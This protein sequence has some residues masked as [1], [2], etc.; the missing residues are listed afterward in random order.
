MTASNREFQRKWLM[1]R[2]LLLSSL[3]EMS[4]V[5]HLPDDRAHLERKQIHLKGIECAL[6]KTFHVDRDVN[7][8]KW[9]SSLKAPCI[10]LKCHSWMLNNLGT[11]NKQLFQYRLYCGNTIHLWLFRETMNYSVCL[12][13]Y[14]FIYIYTERE[15]ERE[16]ER[17]IF[18]YIYIYIYAHS[19]V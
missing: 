15:R 1:N 13:V 6:C 9:R 19:F 7:A 17:E 3:W 8:V 5:A 12:S 16:R 11:H 18:I 14:L 10:D 4:I 2:L